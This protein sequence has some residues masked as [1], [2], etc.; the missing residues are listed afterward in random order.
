M[1]IIFSS[2][3]N[4]LFILKPVLREKTEQCLP[5]LL[6]HI[7]QS[8]KFGNMKN[9][10]FNTVLYSPIDSILINESVINTSSYT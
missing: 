2:T 4:W 6:M 3:T 1:S 7:Y 9:F 10:L 8:D 5:G